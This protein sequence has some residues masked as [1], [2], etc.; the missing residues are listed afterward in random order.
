LQALEQAK[1]VAQNNDIDLE[2]IRRWS[3]VENR[4][5]KFENFKKQLVKP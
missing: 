3:I 2:E 5:G 4:S 1:M